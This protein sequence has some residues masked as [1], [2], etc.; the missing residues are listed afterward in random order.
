MN[1]G[2]RTVGEGSSDVE[3]DFATREARERMRRREDP[4]SGDEGREDELEVD[5]VGLDCNIYE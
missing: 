1:T 4:Q 2:A 5:V 3:E